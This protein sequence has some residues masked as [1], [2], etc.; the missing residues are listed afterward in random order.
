MKTLVIIIKKNVPRNN[1]N[2]TY[3]SRTYIIM[4][5]SH[6]YYHYTKVPSLILLIKSNL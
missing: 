3:R 1:L 2:R 6:T 4:I 5:K